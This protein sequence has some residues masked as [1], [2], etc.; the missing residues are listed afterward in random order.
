M[1]T[2]IGVTPPPFKV[3][4]LDAYLIVDRA[5]Q[6]KRPELQRMVPAFNDWLV[7]A[8][9]RAWEAGATAPGVGLL[10]PE[11]SFHAWLERECIAE[12]GR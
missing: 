12:Y 11:K 7:L 3:P 4:R 1:D 6:R 9:I 5:I 2:I 10:N 8:V